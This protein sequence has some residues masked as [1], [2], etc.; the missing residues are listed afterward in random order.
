MINF[1][2]KNSIIFSIIIFLAIGYSKS[3]SAQISF[4]DMSFLL[5][6]ED[7]HSG[8]AMGIIDMNGDGLD[9]IV[10]QNFGKDLSV[11]LQTVSG[12]KFEIIQ[13]ITTTGS[14]PQ[15][16]MCMA[17][18]DNNGTNEILTGG[19]SGNI[20]VIEYEESSNSFSTQILPDGGDVFVQG[21][22]FADI[23]NDGYVDIFVCH[24]NGESRVWGNDGMGGFI[25]RDEWIDMSV[26]GQSGES[27]SGNYGSTWLDID[28]DGDIDLY[29]AKCRQGV[30]DVNDKRRINQLYIND[31][32]GNFTE[33][34]SAWGLDIGWQS[35]TAD[36]QDINND[37][38]LDCFITNHDY[39][40]Q[41]FL[42]N[43]AGSFIELANTGI[44]VTGLPIQGLLKDFDNDG[45]VDVMTTGSNGQLFINNGDLT[46]TEIPNL[47][48]QSG[49]ESLA[50]GDL[51]NDGYLDIYGGYAKIFN[52]PSSK[53]DIVWM[54]N[55][56]DNNYVA[57]SLVG[58][59]SNRN[60]IGARLEIFGDWGIQ[61]REVRAGES[62][63]I[64]N[65]MVSY[66][67]LG[68][69]ESIDSITIHWP[70]GLVQT[71]Y[72]L[73]VNSKVRIVE[74]NCLGES[75]D[76][77]ITGMT[78]FC[79]GDSVVLTV[80]EDYESY[81]WSNGIEGNSI[82]IFTT[83]NYSIETTD[84]NGCI[85]FS[86][87]IKITVDPTL[88]PT[89]LE[90]DIV[91]AC[92]GEVVELE[93]VNVD[94]DDES[95][96][97]STG[98]EGQSIVIDQSGM[99]YAIVTG[100][101]RDFVSNFVE[102]IINETPD[103][104]EAMG[105]SIKVGE[106][107]VLNAEGDNLVWF[108]TETAYEPIDQ[109]STI[110][111]EGLLVNTSVFVE[112]RSGSGFLG[113]VGMEDHD[114]TLYE[115]NSFF[116]NYLRFDVIAPFTLDSVKVYTDLPGIRKI[117]LHDQSQFEVASI[118]VD[119]EEGESVIYLGFEIP[120]GLN[121]ELKTDLF[122]NFKT[123]GEFTPRLQ[124]S[125]ENVNFPYIA[126]G[127]VAIKGPVFG[128]QNYYY[129]YDWSITS[130]VLCSSPRTEVKIAVDGSVSTID[131]LQ[132]EITIFPNPSNGKFKIHGLDK[133]SS[134]AEYLLLDL[135]GKVLL[136]KK[137]ILENELIIDL[138]LTS[139]MY[140]LQIFDGVKTIREKIII[141]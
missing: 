91:E 21:S 134:Q 3:S 74:G 102:V 33:E 106:I 124:R 58:M 11:E 80:E 96:S 132:N 114:G 20:L 120:A 126:D 42:N 127:V 77:T 94:V 76:I 73:N 131:D 121:Y 70:S 135:S 24:D 13:G 25:P 81:L 133:F 5:T 100:Q 92:E 4:S 22:N 6:N 56:G 95:I 129:F 27:A 46:F 113:N 130:G 60:A 105:D 85:G 61:I 116:V 49:L 64:A 37:G 137:N 48:D 107:A 136:Q 117:I 84:E 19:T 87:N 29:I 45:W 93:V 8:V 104:P 16:S 72:N 123:T 55:G 71:E 36:F 82:S 122:Q 125:T 50:L 7:H 10:R 110:E 15:W 67:G 118:S 119:I 62:Y 44:T 112:D 101:C 108:D 63:G 41:M 2:M 34:A 109:G 115:E 14:S 59:E 51:N 39:E 23:D 31:G 141:E 78:S 138:N 52:N 97:W 12:Q 89:I 90:M 86:E 139:G 65:S 47:F 28:N 40:S 99:Y 54:N 88:F 32:N 38:W 53:N 1:R 103:A 68:N 128:D 69:S 17:D 75:P 35:W 18:I 43:G 57:V 83:G 79:P 66:F 98:E 30:T 140:I 9:D 26:N 111:I